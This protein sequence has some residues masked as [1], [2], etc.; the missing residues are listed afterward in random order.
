MQ[1]RIQH[2][3][4]AAALCCWISVGCGHDHSH[5][6]DGHS[7]DQ[8]E[9]AGHD[10]DGHDHEGHDHDNASEST[11]NANSVAHGEGSQ[12]TA[13]YVCP[14]HCEGSGSNEAGKCPA[15]GMDYVR[16]AEHV[17]DGHHHRE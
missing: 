11:G 12:Y 5:D 15:C 7:H 9:H 17:K 8:T 13:A 2:I 10:H 16:F 4:L 1:I 14:M 6:H 3:V